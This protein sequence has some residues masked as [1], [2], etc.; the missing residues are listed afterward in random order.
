VPPLTRAFMEEELNAEK[1]DG[2]AAAARAG[3]ATPP[4][5]ARRGGG[6]GATPLTLPRRAR[7][8]EWTIIVRPLSL[9]VAALAPGEDASSWLKRADAALYAAKSAGRDRVAM[10]PP[11]PAPEAG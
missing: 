9:G 11:S 1:P 5:A 2:G 3:A 7:P 8:L 4:P 6:V 10:A